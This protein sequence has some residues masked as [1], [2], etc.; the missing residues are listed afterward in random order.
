LRT[1][2]RFQSGFTGQ[3]VFVLWRRLLL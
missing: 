2:S 3:K 1:V